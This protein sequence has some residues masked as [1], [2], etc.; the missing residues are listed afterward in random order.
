MKLVGGVVGLIIAAIVWQ[1]RQSAMKRRLRELDDGRRCIACHSTNMQVHG[2]RAQCGACFHV[3]DLAAI[4][5]AVVSDEQ[6]RDI[7]RPQ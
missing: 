5:A 2:D 4:R 3:S 1:L 6:I 7:T